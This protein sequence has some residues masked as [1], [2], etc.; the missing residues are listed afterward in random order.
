MVVRGADVCSCIQKRENET[1]VDAYALR[2]RGA[3][4]GICHCPELKDSGQLST[5]VGRDVE[6]DDS[7]A[8]RLGGILARNVARLPSPTLLF[9]SQIVDRCR[10]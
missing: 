2:L 4:V 5:M 9:Y 10:G 6:R 8:A 7:D 3:G 1:P